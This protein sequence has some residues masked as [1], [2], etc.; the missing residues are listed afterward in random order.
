MSWLDNAIEQAS[1]PISVDV[2]DLGIGIDQLEIIPL[3]AAEFQILKQDPEI[4]KLVGEDR[5]ETLGLRAV[6]EMVAKCDKSVTWGKWKKLPLVV[7]GEIATRCTN[8]VGS[9]TGGGALGES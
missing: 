8:A 6:F 7:L 1:T 5:N 4:A 2:S 3:S 9:P